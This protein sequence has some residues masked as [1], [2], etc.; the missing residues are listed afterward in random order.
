M[1]IPYY[2]QEELNDLLFKKIQGVPY[3]YQNQ[4]ITLE[5]PGSSLPKIISSNI[6]SKTIPSTAPNLDSSANIIYN[7]R[8]IHIYL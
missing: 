3:V 5:A 8:Y 7:G 2:T 1:S 6:W 4:S